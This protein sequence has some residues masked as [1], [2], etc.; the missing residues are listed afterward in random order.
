MTLD[1]KVSKVENLLQQHRSTRGLR[2]WAKK[3]VADA[4]RR[5]SR[6]NGYHYPQR[7]KEKDTLMFLR[8]GVAL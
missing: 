2:G 4:A 6:H 5:W 1:V 8:C 7:V 3:G